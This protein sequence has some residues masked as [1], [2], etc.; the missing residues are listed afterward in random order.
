MRI[1]RMKWLALLAAPGLLAALAA[2]SPAPAPAAAP[3]PTAA[4]PALPKFE[5]ATFEKDIHPLIEK[6]CYE[7]HGDGMAK[8][9]LALDKYKTVADLEKDATRWETVLD[10]VHRHEMPPD[11]ADA[12]PTEQ[13]RDFLV[14][15]VDR[16]IHQYDP[17]N[18][19][20]GHVTLHRLNRSEYT[21]TIRDLT[22]VNFHADD[23]FPPDDSGYGFD[24]IGDVLSLP[25]MLMEK[26]LNAA[27][28]ILDQAIPTEPLASRTQNFPAYLLE[29][30]F[31]DLGAQAGGWVH[32]ISLE[33]GHVSL[34]QFIPAPGEYKISFEAYGEPTGGYNENGVG[35]KAAADT[36][37]SPEVPKVSLRVSGTA[38][39][40]ETYI[41][42][43][44]V[45]APDKDH[46]GQYSWE[47]SLPAGPVE[48]HEVMERD[49]GGANENIIINGRV[50]RQQ[51]GVAWIKSMTIEGPLPGAIT[52]WSAAKLTATG[53]GATNGAGERTLTGNG[54]VAAKINVAQAGD[55]IL[56]A[57]AYAQQAGD[58]PTKMAF[59][60]DGQPLTTFDVLAPAQR[61]QLPGEKVFSNH[62]SALAL[63]KAV[64][65]VYEFRV[66]LAPGEKTFSA[67]LVNEFAD[68]A[69]P[70][71]NLQRRTLTIQN[72]EVVDLTQPFVQ[73]TLTEEMKGYF[74]QAVTPANKEERARQIITHFAERAWRGPVDPAEV[75]K[76]M[77]LFALADKNGESFP[78]S[79]KL[80]M[81][82]VLVSPHFLF[83]GTAPEAAT[84][85]GAT[86]PQVKKTAF[87]KTTPA[88][89]G[90]ESLGVPVDE[91]TLA[92]R[93]SYF[94]WSS[95]PDDELLG[96]AEHNQL[97]AHLAEQVQ[98]L[99]AS[100]KS[101]ALVDNFA[102][103]WLQFR[104]LA[105]F[106]PDR[107]VL[108]DD[109]YNAWPELC[110]EM[111]QETGRFFD[112]V[113]R[114]D[115]S[116]FDFLTGNYTFVNDDLANYY[117]LPAVAGNEFQKV[118][119]DG[120]PRRG[121]LTQGS[122]LVLTS[123]PTRTSPVKRG[124][125]VLDNLLGTPPPPPPPNVPVLDEESSLTG[126]LRQ[127]MEQHRA[128]PTCASCH[129]R[130][131]PI[132]FGLENF[133][134][135]GLW[136][137]TDKS[138]PID[139]SGT[140]LTGESFNGAAELAQILAD[141][142]RTD[143]LRCLSEKMLTYALGRGLEYYD[144]AATDQIIAQL[145]KGGDKFSV[146]MMGVV[147]SVPFQE[148]RR[149]DTLPDKPAEKPTTTVA[150]A[151]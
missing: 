15:W 118:S 145:E 24:N 26:Y 21:N 49:R 133:D 147:N 120:T 87:A 9:D 100:P 95:A 96:L 79:V 68:P 88:A 127:Q 5:D 17:A 74:A 119:L 139:A 7:C 111:E 30:G 37:T 142:K 113:M 130:M 92:S 110:D 146:L 51:N 93:L 148:M 8:A 134:A 94:F 6:Y 117:G 39:V 25:P 122:V 1:P 32:L 81:K 53:P 50:G 40:G 144:R 27:D 67:A 83:R 80:A 84:L 14:N 98:R 3:T 35:Y 78:V 28:K 43:F 102:G 112:Y 129:A 11:D 59:R 138:S 124:K 115:R 149:T 69:N 63:Q 143:F 4:A 103:Q 116:V 101:Q 62:P 91:L 45:D 70:N 140:L 54:E 109:Y 23:D 104:S 42:Q 20:P 64:P 150:V 73:P 41:H 72:L 10:K 123:N 105:T 16:T 77:G 107:A 126:T 97:R 99:I 89:G 19:D 75:D 58:E 2:D 61:L 151:P 33:E 121:V 137:D 136:R 86:G 90:G 38:G 82:A 34:S 132:G 108:G 52:H 106:N 128:N 57:T 48:L 56:R 12:Q 135:A 125:W 76:L 131:D 44:Q 36:K 13:E 60:L 65:Q 71:P 141:K 47:A 18:P 114:Q 22:G 31:N 29:T 55:Y 85:A 46:P 66:K